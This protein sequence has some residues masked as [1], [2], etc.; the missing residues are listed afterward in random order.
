MRGLP[1]CPIL[2]NAA[3]FS[4]QTIKI[5][6]GMEKANFSFLVGVKGPP[7][8]EPNLVHPY[9]GKPLQDAQGLAKLSPGFAV[10]QLE[11]GAHFGCT[12]KVVPRLR[13]S[14]RLDTNRATTETRGQ[15]Q[16]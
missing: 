11:A 15:S 13:T 10:L 7:K 6:H 9:F 5:A 2:A 12:A 14:C 1:R 3:V 8:K 4:L 16:P